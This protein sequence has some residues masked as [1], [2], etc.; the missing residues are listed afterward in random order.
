MLEA[1]F[2][3]IVSG[4][5]VTNSATEAN[6]A[7]TRKLMLLKFFNYFNPLKTELV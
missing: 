2:K 7:N 3:R 4:S 6:Y 1:L 5:T